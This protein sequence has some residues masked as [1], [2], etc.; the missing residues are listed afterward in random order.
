MQFGGTGDSGEGS[1]W[2]QLVRVTTAAGAASGK[3]DGCLPKGDSVLAI[4]MGQ[5][6]ET[7]GNW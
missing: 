6:A 3:G 7:S 2:K 4:K 1:G 5:L